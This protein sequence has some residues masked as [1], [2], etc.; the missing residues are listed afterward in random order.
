MS[1]LIEILGEPLPRAMGWALAHFVWLGAVI[2]AV[3]WAL[4]RLGAFRS[5][6]ARY[7]AC[8]LALAIC[9]IATGVT[10][11]IQ[12]HGILEQP[13][14]RNASAPNVAP[15]PAA[16]PA[17]PVAP[18]S[19]SPSAT[20]SAASA[21]PASWVTHAGSWIE[22]ALPW[23]VVIW[24]LGVLLLSV[25]LLGSWAF[26][27]HLKHRLLSAVP[28]WVAELFGRLREKLGV[29][30]LVRV[31]ESAAVESPLAIGW[32]RPVVLLP[33]CAIT[34]LTP[35]QL[36]TLLAHELAHIRRHDYLLNLLQSLAET[37]LFFH[38]AI[39]WISARIR[40]ER[41]HCCDDIAIAACGHE[42]EYAE[43]LAALAERR[44]HTA[45]FALSATGGSL[46]GRI[47]RILAGSGPAVPVSRPAAAFAG[48]LLISLIVTVVA[49]AH[50]LHK[51][52]ETVVASNVYA[53]VSRGWPE[54]FR[55]P[56]TLAWQDAPMSAITSAFTA[57]TGLV[58]PL[59]RGAGDE[60]L[61][62][63]FDEAPLHLALDAVMNRVR[64]GW[65][66]VGNDQIILTPWEGRE[67]WLARW[68]DE[69]AGSE[70]EKVY[71]KAG[72]NSIVY[73]ATNGRLDAAL[74]VIGAQMG[75]HFTVPEAEAARLVTVNFHEV[76]ARDVLAQLL[77]P[78]GLDYRVVSDAEIEIF[79]P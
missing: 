6:A 62:V 37:A 20:P 18:A 74:K 41:E 2:A 66:L 28:D 5:A 8:S 46:V 49:Q 33:A 72:Y 24:A 43:A 50:L 65:R 14:P 61:T 39:W 70:F 21:K 36:E 59:P 44:H 56:I 11:A 54:R 75:S 25:R 32:L 10:V 26:T 52:R 73:A 29:R 64:L 67:L 12:Y 34:G 4:L 16:P 19:S 23:F 15:I 1:G 13:A 48:V 55:R 60:L 53:E 38:P 42:L 7:L 47:Q 69:A 22:P 51:Q 40:D 3:L 35:T 45:Q 68:R 76:M 78:L 27:Q 77:P 57:Q 79:R 17:S 71:Y 58:I 63:R 31:F 30:V 9:V